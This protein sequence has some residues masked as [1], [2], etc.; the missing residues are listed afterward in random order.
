MPVKTLIWAVLLLT[1]CAIVVADPPP[2]SAADPISLDRNSPSVVLFG[3]LPADIYGEANGP[4]FGGWDVGG[5]G[6]ILHVWAFAYGLT[7][8]DNNDAHSLGDNN[9]GSIP[10]VYFS[11]S[12]RSKGAWNTQYRNQAVRNQAAGDRFVTNGWMSMSPAASYAAGLPAGLVVWQ[13]G[14]GPNLLSANQ[15]RYN[16]IPSIPQ[17][18]VNPNPNPDQIDDMD[19]LELHPM[20]LNGD[21]IHDLPIYFSLDAASPLLPPG[22]SAADIFVSPAGAPAF[23][24][25]ANSAS[26]GLQATD[27]IDALVVY[28]VSGSGMAMPGIDY[29]LFSLAP[30]NSLGAD[31]SD[32]YVTCFQGVS[33]LY[34]TGPTIGLLKKDNLDGLDVEQFVEG[35]GTFPQIWDELVVT[36][37]PLPDPMWPRRGQP[38]GPINTSGIV[39]LIGTDFLYIEAPDS[40]SGIRVQINPPWYVEPGDDLQ[41]IGNLSSFDGERVIYP[42][43]MP[44]PLTIGNPIPEIFGMRAR[45]VGGRA[46]DVFNPGVTN[47]RGPLNV[48]LLV[49]VSGLVTARD[50]LGQWLYIW[51]GSNMFVP[52]MGSMPLDD[53]SGNYGV[54]VVGDLDCAP[55]TDWVEVTGVVSTSVADIVGTVRPEILPYHDPSKVTS[56][57]DIFAP[58][59]TVLGFPRKNLLSVCAAPAGLGDGDPGGLQ[60]YEASQIFAPGRTQ[61]EI[62]YRLL[63]WDPIGLGFPMY[64]QNSEPNGPFGGVVLGDG[65][66]LKP[67]ANWPLSYSSLHS[68]LSQWIATGPAGKRMI[69]HPQESDI[70]MEEVFV[71]SGREIKTCYDA[72]Q[73]GANWIN[74]KGTFW[75]NAGSGFLTVGLPD[76]NPVEEEL[77][78]WRGYWFTFKQ[79]NK[80]FIIPGKPILKFYQLD[81][82]ELGGTINNSEWGHVDLTFSGYPNPMYFNLAV[83]GSWQVQNIVVGSIEGPGTLQKMTYSFSLGV[84]RGTNVQNIDYDYSLTLQPIGAMPGGA[85]PASVGN[86][87]IRSR[88]GIMGAVIPPVPPAH[89]LGG[90]TPPPGVPLLRGEG[91]IGAE[92]EV[93]HENFPNQECGEDECAPA[94]ISNSLQWLNSTYDLG[95]TTEQ[96][97]IDTWLGWFA[98]HWHLPSYPGA[99]DGGCGYDWPGLKEAYINDP[100]HPYP[101]TSKTITVG[102]IWGEILS[103]QDVEITGEWHCA[104]VTGIKVLDNGNCEITVSHDTKQGEDGGTIT[105]TITYDKATGTLS[106]S[107]DFF[108]GSLV[109]S[110]VSE[111]PKEEE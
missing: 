1:V 96:T 43:E 29:A 14:L 9:P 45:D 73:W 109:T 97:S 82:D 27:N 66:W 11:A 40:S 107:P 24:L 58:A 78:P 76:D 28:S 36:I 13:P 59:G 80:A 64:D 87:T 93:H 41:V 68:T 65:Y 8:A 25:W 10:I 83:N 48:G 3:N 75:D 102:E 104:A 72:S 71:H 90:T 5:P 37:P 35:G 54:R 111:C 103:G 69:G 15:T 100:A 95:M 61:G 106:G 38:D 33:K 81:F 92:G 39:T 2:P 88:S 57:F 91:Y 86:R 22:S 84:P 18:V 51:D 21:H 42:T 110:V 44:S 16:E 49:Y 77:K 63:G 85:I 53:G 32:V 105:E 12:R 17:G 6:P 20:D 94:A 98:I 30:N 31:P 46:L 19:G 52:G 99:G 55:W 23:Q 62:H 70:P 7:P 79:D 89:P 26:M 60:P 50:P 74:S 101:I 67:P 34:F 108:D 47:G 56:F 4:I